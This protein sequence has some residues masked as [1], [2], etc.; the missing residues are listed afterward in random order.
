[1]CYYVWFFGKGPE[2]LDN[3]ARRYKMKKDN[4][5][6]KG[7]V[8][9]GA[10]AEV[11]A[12]LP[13]MVP[14]TP[15]VTVEA[16]TGDEEIVE[17]QVVETGSELVSAE[18]LAAA[19]AIEDGPTE[20]GRKALAEAAKSRAQ[21][22]QAAAE[23]PT[24]EDPEAAAER[25]LA[26][27]AKTPAVG[28]RVRCCGLDCRR[29][30][31]IDERT[32]G[33][34]H[35]R[36]FQVLCEEHARM[37]RSASIILDKFGNWL[38]RLERFNARVDALRSL[39]FT[40]HGSSKEKTH[41]TLLDMEGDDL[42]RAIVVK[43]DVFGEEEPRYII[44]KSRR[45]F[46]V[47]KECHTGTPF[48]SKSAMQ[49]LEAWEAAE[50]EQKRQAEHFRRLAEVKK[51]QYADRGRQKLA[52]VVAEKQHLRQLSGGGSCGE[53]AFFSDIPPRN[54][55]QGGASLSHNPLAGALKA[56]VAKKSAPESA[57]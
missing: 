7:G 34:A 55:E 18:E 2:T 40:E 28:K 46:E 6:K 30:V 23:M 25:E 4:G 41:G 56:I 14:E 43:A 29:I 44:L 17:G 39:S 10:K 32:R 5:A 20:A 35:D 45:D 53:E 24:V 9:K 52:K 33:I 11:P 49:T 51:Q 19:L 27:N 26:E 47:F 12:Q 38:F 1:M 15:V 8:K 48:R 13:E 3:Y 31:E 57:N 42:Q 22:E 36:S 54:I 21:A 50:R 37:A 16:A